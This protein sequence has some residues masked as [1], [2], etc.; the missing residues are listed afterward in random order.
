MFPVAQESVGI[1]IYLFAHPTVTTSVVCRPRDLCTVVLQHS[2]A[3]NDHFDTA[4][5]AKTRHYQKLASE[6]KKLSEGMGETRSLLTKL[7]NDLGSMRT[8]AGLH[9]A[10]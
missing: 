7:E 9:A 2:Y 3:M 5:R 1:A 4:G 8:L 6:L 10:Q